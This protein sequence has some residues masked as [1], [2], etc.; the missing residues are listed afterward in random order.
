MLAL[1]LRRAILLITA[2]GLFSFSN[3][4]VSAQARSRHGE[5]GD[6]VV[7]K[8]ERAT[9]A[10]QRF[11]WEQGVAAQAFLESRRRGDGDPASAWQS[12]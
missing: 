8:V 9:L 6:P 3:A 12:A 10:M 1:F 11:S 4:L 7:E 2:T 5:P